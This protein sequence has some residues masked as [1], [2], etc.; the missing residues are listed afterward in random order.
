MTDESVVMQN[1]SNGE[2]HCDILEEIIG[3]KPE[4]PYQQVGSIRLQKCY[5]RP[6]YKIS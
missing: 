2:I 3:S 4:Y 1:C 6:Y 5:L